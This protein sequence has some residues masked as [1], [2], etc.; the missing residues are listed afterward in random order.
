MSL[1]EFLQENRTEL[2]EQTLEHLGL[3]FLSLALAV[4]I[5]LPLGVWISRRKGWDNII[6]GIAGILQTV[7]S[8]ALLGF[9]IPLLGI[10]FKP[11]IFALLL[12]ALLPI[13]RNTY[14]GILN[15]DASVK[16]AAI[17]M[18][19]TPW[20][21][22]TKVELPLAMPVIFAG[23]RTATVINVGVATLASY[24]GAGGLGEFIF[25]GIALNNPNMIFAG[26]LCAA[27]LAILFDQLLA[28]VNKIPIRRF[29]RTSLYFSILIPVFSILYFIPQWT[30]SGLS[31]GADPEFAGRADGYPK[32]AAL[33]NLDLNTKILNAGLMYRAVAEGEVDVISGY[34]TDGRIKAYNLMVLKDD[35]NAFPP[36]QCAPLIS[37]KLAKEHPEVA[38]ALNL[39]AGKISDS[40]M[41]VLNY[42]VDFNHEKP[43]DVAKDFLVN[44][45]L[46]KPDRKNGGQL[47]KIGS[48]IFTEQYILAHLFAQLINGY[49][50]FDVDVK[51]G[52][53][54]TK[55]CFDALHAGAIDLYPEY[56]GTGFQVLLSPT[57][58]EVNRLIT[59]A[60]ALYDYVDQAFLQQYDI[61]WLEPLGFNNTYALVIRHKMAEVDH[62]QTISDLAKLKK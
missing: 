28:F 2:Y 21:V 26:A 51:T 32:L 56:T 34:S 44:I 39:L 17:G 50:D 45:K 48:K 27:L 13:L 9:L 5:A 59:N 7:P 42:R 52:L 54:G 4:L 53:G 25:G 3:T 20:Q 31:I 30:S 49:T 40:T 11:A 37:E 8:I 60:P 46:W 36:Y 6:L 1:F 57:E 19:M 43:E 24:I 33:Y 62:L 38:E 61:D 18:G 47:L 55:V 29:L 23:I 58:S 16:E 14:T 41:T 12:Y 15:V 22:L 35:K 10:G